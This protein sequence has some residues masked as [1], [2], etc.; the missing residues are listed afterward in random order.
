MIQ[1][2]PIWLVFGSIG[3]P[4]LMQV[5]WPWS[6]PF[7]DVVVFEYMLIKSPEVQMDWVDRKITMISLDLL[8]LLLREFDLPV[9]QIHVVFKSTLSL[10]MTFWD[11]QSLQIYTVFKTALSPS[12]H[13]RQIYNFQDYRVWCVQSSNSTQ[14]T[15]L[16]SVQV[17]TIYI[18]PSIQVFTV[19]LSSLPCLQVFIFFKSTVQLKSTQL[20]SLHDSNSTQFTSL[21]CFEVSTI[22][23]SPSLKVF[24]VL[25]SS[26][27]NLQDFTI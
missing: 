8:W 3:F 20:N 17:S 18:S 2:G 16:Q 11:L 14:F 19:L 9:F 12:L 26:P 4:K 24:T 5:K 23:I 27:H 7:R 10:S 21:Q 6:E 13:S 22:F 1:L 25:S 15:S